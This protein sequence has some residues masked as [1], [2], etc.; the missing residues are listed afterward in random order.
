VAG[1][2]SSGLFGGISSFPVSIT[3]NSPAILD[4]VTVMVDYV[5]NNEKVYKSETI[6]Y[7]NLGPGETVTLKAPKSSRG[8]KINIRIQEVKPRLYEPVVSH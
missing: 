5:Q 4:Q 7:N 3:N 6:Q 8:T 2:Y 1:H